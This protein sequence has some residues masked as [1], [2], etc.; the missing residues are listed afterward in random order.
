LVLYTYTAFPFD[1]HSVLYTRESQRIEFYPVH[2][3]PLLRPVVAIFLEV[4]EEAVDLELN[5]FDL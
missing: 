3:N 1:F 4:F 5:N 2:H